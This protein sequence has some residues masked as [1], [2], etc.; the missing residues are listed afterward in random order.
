[1]QD[2]APNGLG[3]RA[4]SNPLSN[5]IGSWIVMAVLVLL[6]SAAAIIG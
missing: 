4:A 1:M 6:L 5:R 2:N 3:T